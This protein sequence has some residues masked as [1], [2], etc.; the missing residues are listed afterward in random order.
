[1]TADNRRPRKVVSGSQVY[2]EDDL[3]LNEAALAAPLA[4]P[5][6]DPAHFDELVLLYRDQ[7]FHLVESGDGP[8]G[9]T[10]CGV[11]FPA[12]PLAT[13]RE[14]EERYLQTNTAAVATARAEFLCALHPS[15]VGAA[16]EAVR[17]APTAHAA[18]AALDKL[19][20][21]AAASP[22][23]PAKSP[24]PAGHVKA[25]PGPSVLLRSL[26]GYDR[27]LLLD[28]RG[29]DL[30]TTRE[31]FESWKRGFHPDLA[32]QVLERPTPWPAVELADFLLKNG[33]LANPRALSAACSGL[34]TR[35]RPLGFS[36]D[37]LDLIPVPRGSTASFLQDWL[38]ALAQD[39]KRR[40][41]ADYLGEPPG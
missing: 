33:S 30:L 34:H 15:L 31:F 3:K 2:F 5:P 35:H 16:G 11:S 7:L 25:P 40:A 21:L 1:M 9:M 24:V 4:L 41:L 22:G 38:Q 27:S 6:L 14:A 23:R 26:P 10:L 36:L 12:V 32:Q 29:Y 17:T 8:D 37:G 28:G 18:S 19:R 39:L 20:L 13:V